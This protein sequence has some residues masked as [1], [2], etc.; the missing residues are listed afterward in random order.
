MAAILRAL[1]EGGCVEALTS[2]Q[3]R[4]FAASYEARADNDEEIVTLI[5]DDEFVKK[6]VSGVALHVGGVVHRVGTEPLVDVHVTDEPAAKRARVETTPTRNFDT[7]A[8]VLASLGS[9][10]MSIV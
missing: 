4:V 2:M 9:V 6:L 5:F 8:D 3:E 7:F 1:L 10:R